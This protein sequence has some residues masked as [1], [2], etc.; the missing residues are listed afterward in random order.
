MSNLFLLSS[1]YRLLKGIFLFLV[2]RC[3]LARG[4]IC[5]PTKTNHVFEVMPASTHSVHSWV[6]VCNHKEG[7]KIHVTGALAKPDVCHIGSQLWVCFPFL[8]LAMVN[9]QVVARHHRKA[10]FWAVFSTE[11]G[12]LLTRGMVA[13]N[14]AV[15]LKGFVRKS[16][17]L[18]LVGSRGDRSFQL[19]MILPSKGG[20]TKPVLNT[21]DIHMGKRIG[22]PQPQTDNPSPPD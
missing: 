3:P 8:D 21:V 6:I 15:N 18:Y 2:V 17:S 5:Q 20:S 12:R 4:E 19:P 7:A 22:D 13:G 9:Q 11:N 1:L 16:T 14:K 10:G